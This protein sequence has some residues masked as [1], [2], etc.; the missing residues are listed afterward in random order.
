MKVAHGRAGHTR[1]SVGHQA[2]PNEGTS[3]TRRAPLV[4]RV[5]GAK[6]QSGGGLTAPRWSKSTFSIA[7][8][9]GSRPSLKSWTYI[10]VART[11]ALYIATLRKPT[12]FNQCSRA[13]QLVNLQ[14]NSQ[15]CKSRNEDEPNLL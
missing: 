2:V 14:N 7:P 11:R 15:P 10:L 5:S 4:N 1:R 8:L 6:Q 13:N 3:Q 9:S 12:S